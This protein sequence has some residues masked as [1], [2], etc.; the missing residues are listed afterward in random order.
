MHTVRPDTH[1]RRFWA[2]I[3]N[4]LET[5]F[6]KAVTQQWCKGVS[7]QR[8]R[9]WWKGFQKQAV[10]TVTPQEDLL[11][12]LMRLLFK[13]IILSTH[14]VVYCEMALFRDRPYRILLVT[15]PTGFG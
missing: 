5:L 6:T 4:I 10:R 9:Y 15:A 1:Y 7:T 14:S 2:S 13:G 3:S 8:Q 12:T 11:C